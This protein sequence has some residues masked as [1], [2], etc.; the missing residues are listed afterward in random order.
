MACQR[1][2]A[3]GSVVGRFAFIGNP[4]RGR[5]SVS[6]QSAMGIRQLYRKR[7]VA[8]GGTA[9]SRCLRRS[10]GSSSGDRRVQGPALPDD[11]LE[12]PLVVLERVVVDAEVEQSVGGCHD[13]LAA[14][15][16]EWLAITE[17]SD[18]RAG[19]AVGQRSGSD[20]AARFRTVDGRNVVWIVTQLNLARR[21]EVDPLAL[22]ERLAGRGPRLV[23]LHGNRARDRGRRLDS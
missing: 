22:L 16:G 19:K 8:P 23:G 6:F 13:H 17:T 1:A 4:V 18:Q 11:D 5:F 9:G 14:S 7:P 2:S 3:S 21:V 15:D 10:G 12:I 20:A